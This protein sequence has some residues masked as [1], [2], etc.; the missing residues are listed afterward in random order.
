LNKEPENN[1]EISGNKLRCINIDCVFN[2]ANDSGHIRNTCNHPNLH[3]ESKFA[4][5]TIAICSEF[6]S[7]KD[8]S[9]QKPA[10]LIDLKSKEKI[11]IS[12]TPD[13][14]ATPFEKVTT[15]E[16]EESLTP[17][18]KEKQQRIEQ[19]ADVQ[20][21]KPVVVE[22]APLT[23]EVLTPSEI[24]NL[25]DKPGTDFLILKKLYRP[26]MKRG[27]VFSVIIHI[28]ALWMLFVF[29]SPKENKDDPTQQQRIVVIE[30][31]ETPKFDPPDVD[32]QKEEEQKEKENADVKDNTKEVRPKITPKSIKPRI[33]R[34]KNRTDDTTEITN[35][36]NDS[37]KRA[38]D[39]LLALKN[40]LD[41]TKFQIPDSLR[42]S[43]MQ[44]AIG[45]SIS[46]IP[47]N[48]KVTDNRTVDLNKEQ[49]NGVII[50]TDSASD[51]PGAVQ[52]FVIIDD[53]QHSAFN[54]TIY[55][56]P[57]RM[58]DSTLSA[59]STDPVTTG[60]KRI[61]YKFFV[62]VDNLGKKNIAISSETKKELFDKYKPYI[63]AIIRSIKIVSPPSSDKKGP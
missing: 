61:S 14:T 36:N 45:L 53:P 18:Q 56:N 24:Y 25:T 33:Y 46:A 17:E 39:S 3:V 37:L 40:K 19:A 11:E 34:P 38:V 52:I 55:K 31:Y 20:P 2:S 21:E 7:K 5:I 59:F 15:E 30:D 29:A 4:D 10:T 23:S 12:G 60:A 6:R 1:N 57:F 44:D 42:S 51:D 22:S 26:N 62:Y 54:K 8:Y 41:T 47:K 48:W 32:K 35:I 58:D 28:F 63:D 13:I 43:Y 16:L 50:N 9:F 27:M 49:F